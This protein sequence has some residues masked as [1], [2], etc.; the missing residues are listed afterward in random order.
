MVKAGR[1]REDLYYRIHVIPIQ[2]PALRDRAGD[3]PLLIEHYLYVFC[4]VNEM[5]LKRIEPEAMD[6]LESSEWPGNVR[7]LEN[8]VHRLVLMTEGDTI[9]V[10]DLP[11][12]LLQQTAAGQERILIPEEGVD[13]DVEIM[14]IEMAYLS[15]ALRRAGTKTAAAALLQIPVRKMKYLCLKYGL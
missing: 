11:Q 3:V 13:F 9:R 12:P 2:I 6:V 4:T 5:P 1:F 15:T 14:Q 8:L 7:E 10:N